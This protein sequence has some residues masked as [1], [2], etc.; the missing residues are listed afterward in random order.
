MSRLYNRIEELCKKKGITITVMCR[1]SGAPRGSLTDLKMDRISTLSADTLTK[2]A[3]YFGVSV[4]YLLGTE[5]QFA[6]E[7]PE[8][9][10]LWYSPMR[11]WKQINEDR[12]LFMH[13]FLQYWEGSIEDIEK[14]WNVSVKDPDRASDDDFKRFLL[15]AVKAVQFDSG[16]P[17]WEIAINKKAPTQQG[18]AQKTKLRSVARLED[19]SLS[20]DEDKQ[21][22][23]L[24]EWF[25]KNRGNNE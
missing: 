22:S 6:P 16:T 8:L 23:E 2:I 14:T 4:G 11:F 13:Y 24:I 9:G 20:D 3:S 17:E 1:E 18:R 25:L 5:A 19:A 10:Y 21:I 15:D 7:F 12:P